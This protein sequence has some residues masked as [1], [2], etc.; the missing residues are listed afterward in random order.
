[1]SD[2]KSLQVPR[3]EQVPFRN[4]VDGMENLHKGNITPFSSWLQGNAMSLA[5]SG[6]AF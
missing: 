4:P 2:S 6:N 3:E 5:E 1:M